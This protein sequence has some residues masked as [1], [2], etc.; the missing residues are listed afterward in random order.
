M[1]LGEKISML[2][3]K[4][5]IS[6]EKLAEVIGVSRQAVTKWENKNANPDTENLIRLAEFFGVSLDELCKNVSKKINYAPG[7]ILAF[8]S[9]LILAAYCVIGG[10]TKNFDGNVL[11]VLIILTV[12]HLQLGIM[13]N[14]QKLIL[15]AYILMMVYAAFRIFSNVRDILRS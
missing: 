12:N 4:E 3:K 7:H 5:G 14:N 15:A 10:I 9:L 1:T 8:V 2:R 11:V 13:T 6:Q